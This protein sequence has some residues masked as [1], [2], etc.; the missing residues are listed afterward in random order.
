MNMTESI[1]IDNQY[2]FYDYFGSGKFHDHYQSDKY[3]FIKYKDEYK[4]FS[5]YPGMYTY[6]FNMNDEK[7]I[8]S[9]IAK[10]KDKKIPR[11]IWIEDI[12]KNQ[13]IIRTFENNNFQISFTSTGMHLEIEKM[14][15]VHNKINKENIEIKLVN[16]DE[17]LWK[18]ANTLI[19]GWW[20][21]AKGQEKDLYQLYKDIY[22]NHSQI[23]LYLAL[24]KGEPAGTSLAF[25]D[26]K[27]IG[28]YLIS[29]HS[30]F[31]YKGIG[32]LLTATPIIGANKEGY[33]NAVLHAT[34]MGEVIYKQLGFKEH[35]KT[36]S[37]WLNLN[38]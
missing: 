9:L 32:K 17:L 33:N 5:F 35:F 34:E 4:T 19:G 27:S 12:E 21:G 26:K 29:T 24:Y 37:Y 23:R 22:M 7:D 6:A 3:C 10:M 31:R 2:R 13:D 18:W 28:L 14:S 8:E 38:K 20:T 16:S 25:L 30:N 15:E 36:K 1:I 11:A